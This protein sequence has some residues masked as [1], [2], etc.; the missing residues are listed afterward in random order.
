MV[1]KPNRTEKRIIAAWK[2]ADIDDAYNGLFASGWLSDLGVSVTADGTFQNAPKVHPDMP[3]LLR[4]IGE[5]KLASILECG[6][7]AVTK[8][9][10]PVFHMVGR[11]DVIYVTDDNNVVKFISPVCLVCISRCDSH[12]QPVTGTVI[13]WEARLVH[14]GRPV[15]KVY[16]Q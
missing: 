9:S 7:A 5:S 11:M 4:D 15:L 16:P 10:A 6:K 2:N 3:A 14:G 13:V 8:A 12:G 1:G